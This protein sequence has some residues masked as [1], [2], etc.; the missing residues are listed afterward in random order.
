MS[1]LDRFRSLRFL[2]AHDTRAV[3]H[4]FGGWVL[5]VAVFMVVAMT[6]RRLGMKRVHSASSVSTAM[7]VL[8]GMLYSLRSCKL[9]CAMSM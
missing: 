2:R 8:V 9:V 1:Q 6:T 5:F 7:N 4:R 3:Q